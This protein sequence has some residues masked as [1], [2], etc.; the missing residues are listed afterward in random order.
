MTVQL[1]LTVDSADTEKKR[2][3][4]A[5]CDT[6]DGVRSPIIG[7]EGPAVSPRNRL[8]ERLRR[9]QLVGLRFIP[10]HRIAGAEVDFFC[11]DAQLIIMC[12]ETSAP[13]DPRERMETLMLMGLK[14]LR[15]TPADIEKRMGHVLETIAE[16]AAIRLS[17]R[18]GR[19]R[20]SNYMRE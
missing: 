1:A 6:A 20:R 5:V 2:G 8:W 7:A 3:A 15:F 9:A 10:N 17:R 18:P 4:P 16:V 11:H 19:R 14:T 13:G 12:R